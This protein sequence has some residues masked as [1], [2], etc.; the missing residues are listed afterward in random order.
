M[1]TNLYIYSGLG[2]IIGILNSLS[3]DIKINSKDVIELNQKQGIAFDQL[4][5]VL[6]PL[7][8]EN[9]LDV[10]IYNNDGSKASNCI[11]GARCVSK[12]IQDQS[13]LPSNNLKVNTEGGI[14]NLKAL[15]EDQFSATFAL[16]DSL[17]KVNINH[18]NK[19]IV[20]DCI[21]LGNPH[22]VAFEENMHDFDFKTFGKYLQDHE[23][24]EDGVNFGLIS[25]KG[26]DEINLRVFERGAGETLACGSGA[27]AAAVIGIIKRELE[28][29]VKVNFELGSLL[30][31]YKEE[32]K[33][34]S[35]TGNA[36]FL[37]KKEITI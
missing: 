30:I 36:E 4:I 8:H 19:D 16:N 12:F 17:T 11:N 22:G 23:C 29:P 7:H 31:D 3:A 10:E 18:N 34:I 28:T 13:L 27:C 6:P 14:W 26:A 37:E 1:Q 21:N 15:N 5:V 32:S 25:K 20:L 9:D 35:A 2:N 24:F 33:M